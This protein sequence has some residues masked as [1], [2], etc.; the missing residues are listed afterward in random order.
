M[1]SFKWM[2]LMGLVS[3]FSGSA[4]AEQYYGNWNSN[5]YRQG[6]Q[7]YYYYP[8]QTTNSQYYNNNAQSGCVHG[9]NGSV[10]NHGYDVNR[11]YS[12]YQGG[13]EISSGRINYNGY[14]GNNY[15]HGGN[16]SVIDGINRHE[17]G[18][19]AIN[20]KRMEGL[21]E[22]AALKA[23]LEQRR[24]NIS[25]YAGHQQRSQID[26][27]LRAY[28]TAADQLA[29]ALQARDSYTQGVHA[30]SAIDWGAYA[31]RQDLAYR[32]RWEYPSAEDRQ[33]LSNGA[34][35]LEVLKRLLR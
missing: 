4:L 25:T 19:A 7:Q 27:V 14:Q 15:Y 13:S 21:G 8:A 2:F 32:D 31:M 35:T 3:L 1:L 29:A 6:G 26:T 9:P 11:N 16:Q 17:E 22:I 18:N 5:Y 28:Q 23:D 10:C 30:R 34:L 20:K 33:R 24:A 12:V